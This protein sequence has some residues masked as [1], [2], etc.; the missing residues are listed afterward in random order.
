MNHKRTSGFTAVELVAVLSVLLILAG[1][2]TAVFISGK[3]SAIT[4]R[5]SNA[6]S[7]LNAA[8]RSLLDFNS[9]TAPGLG[10]DP[11][12]PPADAPGRILALKA[13]GFLVTLIS[14]EDVVLVQTN[15]V[16][17]WAPVGP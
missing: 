10:L 12:A 17:F 8:E 4:L 7:T 11:I 16:Y 13:A 6:A 9:S 14:T 3:D 5:R 2:V 1:I 15:G